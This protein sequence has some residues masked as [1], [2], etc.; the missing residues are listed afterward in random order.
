MSA[1]GKFILPT[2]VTVTY[3][4]F[5]DISIKTGM[6]GSNGL[7]PKV[8]Y[9][10]YQCYVLPR[11][12]F[13]LETIFLSKKHIKILTDFHM[14]TLRKLQALPDRTSSAAVL[15]LLGALP[16]EAELDKRHL[17]LL[18][19]CLKS[20]NSKLISLAK[21]QT[22]FYDS[23]GRSFF[24]RVQRMLKKYEL[25]GIDSLCNMDISKDQWKINTKRAVRKYWTEKLRLEAYEKSTLKYCNISCLQIGRTHHVWAIESTRLE[26]RRGVVKSR[27]VTGT[28][29]TVTTLKI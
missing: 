20:G 22:L 25:P 11:L 26:V 28:Y 5:S 18:F 6:H 19:S 2:V 23:D 21:R 9:K 7:N 13:G 1:Q 4:K 16:L 3:G 15:L 27:I 17:S 14:D 29:S 24:T 8:S 12:L 10:M